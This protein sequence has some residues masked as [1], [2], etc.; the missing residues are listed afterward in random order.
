MLSVQLVPSQPSLVLHAHEYEANVLVHV[1]LF[2][3]VCDDKHSLMSWHKLY[4]DFDV[5]MAVPLGHV[6]RRTQMPDLTKYCGPGQTNWQTYVV[7]LDDSTAMSPAAYFSLAG[8]KQTAYPL[9]T[10]SDSDDGQT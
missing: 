10:P 7:A 2:W 6:M 4:K 1:P 5:S 3:Q 8:V 9:L